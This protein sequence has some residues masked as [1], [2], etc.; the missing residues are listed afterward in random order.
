[1]TRDLRTNLSISLRERTEAFASR[2]SRRFVM[3]RKKMLTNEQLRDAK[4]FED[5]R[6][7]KKKWNYY[8]STYKSTC[9]RRAQLLNEWLSI[10]FDE[11]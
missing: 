3:F 6:N 7:C 8:D 5:E 11:Q 4:K 9:L 10:A 1:L 2:L